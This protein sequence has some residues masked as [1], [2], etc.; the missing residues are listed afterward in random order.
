ML[1]SDRLL[2][3]SYVYKITIV[4]RFVAKGPTAKEK[5]LLF[6]SLWIGLN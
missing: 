6:T 5:Y 4:K 1:H 2:P 3:G